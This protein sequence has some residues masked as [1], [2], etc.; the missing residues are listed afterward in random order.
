MLP[1]AIYLAAH[2]GLKGS[3]VA[4]KPDFVIPPRRS[5]ASPHLTRISFASCHDFPA[6]QSGEGNIGL[7]PFNFS[8]IGAREPEALIWVGISVTEYELCS[9][10][11]LLSIV[12][13]AQLAIP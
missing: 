11:A 5:T 6:N 8:L 1:A 10:F 7:R 2:F 9:I 13:A 3:L 4:A 12:D